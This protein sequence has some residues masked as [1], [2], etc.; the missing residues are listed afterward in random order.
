[1]QS[2]PLVSGAGNSGEA[3]PKAAQD[4]LPTDKGNAICRDL[5]KVALAVYTRET[6]QH[7]GLSGT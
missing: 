4:Q 7:L 2:L 1:M 5:E 3:S 6:V